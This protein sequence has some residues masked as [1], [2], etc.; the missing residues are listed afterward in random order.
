MNVAKRQWTLGSF[1]DTPVSQ[2]LQMQ[3]NESLMLVLVT[4]K[5][6]LFI[7]YISNH[8]PCSIVGNAPFNFLDNM[9]F[10]TYVAL[11]QPNAAALT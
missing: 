6:Y 11:M 2:S 7:L 10:K 5:T 9:H 8:L 3:M 4:G 1:M